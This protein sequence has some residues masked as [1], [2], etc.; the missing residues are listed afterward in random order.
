MCLPNPGG[1][2]KDPL[3]KRM[4]RDAMKVGGS[5]ALV[6]AA[7]GDSAKRRRSEQQ[8]APQQQGTNTGPAQQQVPRTVGGVLQNKTLLGN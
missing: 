1:H 7:H 2:R 4:D 5:S 3:S 8:A 6:R